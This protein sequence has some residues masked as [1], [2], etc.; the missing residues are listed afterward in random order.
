MTV[1]QISLQNHTLQPLIHFTLE[2][3]KGV[4][5]ESTEPDQMPH[6]V[7]SDLGLH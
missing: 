4:L 2:T 5:A 6:N 1:L 3:P 7:A